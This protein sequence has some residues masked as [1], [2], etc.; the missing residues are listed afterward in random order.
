M[1]Y[2]IYLIYDYNKCVGI[3]MHFKNNCEF[4]KLFYTHKIL[5]ALKS[6]WNYN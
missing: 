1:Q 6:R 3:N 4:I 2:I 5:I